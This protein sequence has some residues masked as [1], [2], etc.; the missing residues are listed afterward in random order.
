M[1]NFYLNIWPAK[2]I[3]WN[4]HFKQIRMSKRKGNF[5]AVPALLAVLLV[6]ILFNDNSIIGKLMD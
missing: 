2:Q 1:L 4:K 5:M 3:K 6:L